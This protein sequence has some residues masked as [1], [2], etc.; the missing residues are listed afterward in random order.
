[1][2]MKHYPTIDLK[3]TGQQIVRLRKERGLTVRD[4]QDYFGFDAPQA[5]YKWQN[6]QT[7]P[8]VDNLFALSVLLEVPMNAILI[9]MNSPRLIERQDETCRSVFLLCKRPRAPLSP[10]PCMRPAKRRPLFHCRLAFGFA[11]TRGLRILHS[12][13]LNSMLFQLTVQ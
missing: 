3:A 8:S 13:W 4:M 10:K 11:C 9:Q 2:Q 5:I 7:L 12:N 1:M 6:G